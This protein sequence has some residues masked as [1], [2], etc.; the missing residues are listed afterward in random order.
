M[1]DQVRLAQ[2]EGSLKTLKL[3]MVCVLIMN[4]AA[5]AWIFAPLFL[6]P[7]AVL[8]TVASHDDFPSWQ[9][10]TLDQKLAKASVIAITENRVE[11]GSV[12]GYIKEILKRSPNAHFTLQVGDEV[13]DQRHAVKPN[14]TYGDGAVVFFVGTSASSW[15]SMVIYAGSIPGLENMSVDELKRAIA[16][17]K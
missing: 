7:S 14:S 15:A 17:A 3:L 5:L 12:H 10:L 6:L 13:P 8:S 16:A 4:V 1:D 9:A 2:I 11:D